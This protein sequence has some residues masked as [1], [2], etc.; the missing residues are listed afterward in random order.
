MGQDFEY[1]PQ[2]T[3]SECRSSLI[4]QVIQY[5]KDPSSSSVVGS[6]IKALIE[7]NNDSKYKEAG[8]RFWKERLQGLKRYDAIH[9]IDSKAK[10]GNIAFKELYIDAPAS[11]LK[12]IAQSTLCHVAWALSLAKMTA[13]TDIFFMTLCSGRQIPGMDL[14]RTS[15][16]LARSAPFRVAMTDRST[17]MRDFLQGVQKT[18]VS[19]FAHENFADAALFEIHGLKQRPSQSLFNY[20]TEDNGGTSYYEKDGEGGGQE[21]LKTTMS[22]FVGWAEPPPSI[23]IAMQPVGNKKKLQMIHDQKLVPTETATSLL[24]DLKS[25]ILRLNEGK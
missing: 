13:L 19:G 7:R 1:L 9:A 24:E 6:P 16:F 21:K 25:Y 14:G 5:W 15:G 23:Y 3:N 2:S 4:E 11:T 20:S 8:T 17:P 22:G 10:A 18:F 12:G